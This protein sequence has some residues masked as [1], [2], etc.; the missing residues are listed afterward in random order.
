MNLALALTLLRLLLAPVVVILLLREQFALLLLLFAVAAL[1]DWLD[2]YVARRFGMVTRLG[3]L[4]DPL[5]DKVLI[6]ATVVAL[7]WV[8]RLPLWLT[9]LVLARDIL[10]VGGAAAY[11]LLTGQLEMAPTRLGKLNTFLQLTLLLA[12]VLDAA[13]WLA[14]ASALPYGQMAVA[15]TTVLSGAGYV[16]RWGGKA[17]AWRRAARRR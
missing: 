9:L 12:V 6:G 17:L 11:R 1:S 4:L 3:G 5:A 10:I 16:A 13:R 15:A 2:G 8:G 14:L 7:T